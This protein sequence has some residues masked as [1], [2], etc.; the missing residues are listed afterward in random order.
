VADLSQHSKL[1]LDVAAQEAKRRGHNPVSP[2]HLLAGLVRQNRTKFTEELGE[3][4]VQ[5]LASAM[6]KRSSAVLDSLSIEE[7]TTDL[8]ARCFSEREQWVVLKESGPGIVKANVKTEEPEET[9]ADDSPSGSSDTSEST[10]IITPSRNET[11]VPMV[12]VVQQILATF[13]P[14]VASTALGQQ[15]LPDA[16][17]HRWFAADPAHRVVLQDIWDV[18]VSVAGSD[19]EWSDKERET[20]APVFRPYIGEGTD[21]IALAREYPV[22]ASFGQPSQLL[23]ALV[24]SDETN[25]TRHAYAFALKLVELGRLTAA[26]DDVVSKPEAEMIDQ[27]R[28]LVRSVLDIKSAS[29]LDPTVAHTSGELS[30]VDKV[31][32]KLDALIGLDSV[33]KEIRTRLEWFR[34]NDL[35]RKRG[36]PA[37]PQALHM[38]FLGNPG[39]G[40]TT[41]ARLVGEL[42]AAAGA[43]RKGHLVEADRSKL[44]AQYLGQTS[45]L[46][47]DTIKK[48]TGGVLFIDE[49][50]SLASASGSRTGG[51]S[52]EREAVDTLVKLMEDKRD[53]LIVIFAGY[54]NPMKVFLESNE[55]L[56]SRV[57]TVIEFTDYDD[58]E[59]MNVFTSMCELNGRKPTDGAIVAVRTWMQAEKET[60]HFGNARAARNLLEEIMR[61]QALRLSSLGDLAT[62]EELSAIE[63]DDVP[64]KT[65][66]KTDEKPAAGYV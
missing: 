22:P 17:L 58:S 12:E 43:L 46:V 66:A 23:R 1:L 20:L 62:D 37:E 3:Q 15:T 38:A 52:F 21:A 60:Q 41:I 26:C 64:V 45:H 65:A 53:D 49:A 44:V 29:A 19:A 9:E 40:K 35:R 59:L 33:K 63:A 31:L 10:R 36:L 25:G 34:I 18:V 32:V 8:A 50:Y 28:L 13:G 61:K 47:H 14:V 16:V 2:L 24:N 57:P 55:G 42:F 4:L 6:K 7:E 39:T 11:P 27:L 5:D 48:A 56:A 30:E 54:S 51:D